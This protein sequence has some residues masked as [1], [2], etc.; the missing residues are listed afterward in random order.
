MLP[1]CGSWVIEA[2]PT[3]IPTLQIAANIFFCLLLGG[4]K[5]SVDYF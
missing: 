5:F 1:H 2:N 3:I 4:Y